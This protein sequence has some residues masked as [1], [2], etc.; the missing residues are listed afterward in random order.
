MTIGNSSLT[1]YSNHLSLETPRLS[2][3]TSASSSLYS[4]NTDYYTPSANT[5]NPLG[6]TQTPMTMDSF[7]NATAFGVDIGKNYPQPMLQDPL[8]ASA[9]FNFDFGNIINMYNSY[10][11]NVKNNLMQYLSATT[12]ASATQ[13]GEY[14]PAT[15][16]ENKNNNEDYITE[17]QPMMQDKVKQLEAYAQSKGYNFTITSGYRTREQQI[18]L[19]QRYANQP[20][21]V[22]G[23]D[24]SLHRFGLAIDINTSGLTE[25]QC[26]DL[27]SYAKSLG[28]RWGGDFNSFREPWHFDLQQSTSA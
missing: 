2:S 3:C 4:V 17:L 28:M 26:A 8:F 22:A 7:N 11:Q 18:A 19:Q 16:V 10:M 21:R 20:G 9:N 23:A 5:D 15:R 12:N 1:E 13:T 27:G 24:S 25:A 14:T 6:I